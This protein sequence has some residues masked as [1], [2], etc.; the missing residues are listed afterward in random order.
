M[1]P[2]LL[3][4]VLFALLGAAARSCRALGFKCLRDDGIPLATRATP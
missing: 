3:L 2:R 1:I 4:P